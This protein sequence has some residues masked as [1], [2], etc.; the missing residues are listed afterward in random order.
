MVRLFEPVLVGPRGSRAGGDTGLVPPGRSRRGKAST[1]EPEPARRKRASSASSIRFRPPGT[2]PKSRKS[3]ALPKRRPRRPWWK[4]STR[5]WAPGDPR[6]AM[7][8][9]PGERPSGREGIRSSPSD[10]AKVLG[11]IDT[12]LGGE[13]RQGDAPPPPAS[14][15]ELFSVRKPKEPAGKAAAGEAQPDCWRESTNSS[16]GKGSASRGSFPHHRRA[17]DL[18][19]KRLARQRR[20]ADYGLNAEPRPMARASLASATL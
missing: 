1:E 18:N 2:S 12:K 13:I 7:R 4:T 20:G 14:D 8:P 6:E 16:D 19:G 15:P 10:P 5:R 9:S 3:R 17:P 11:D